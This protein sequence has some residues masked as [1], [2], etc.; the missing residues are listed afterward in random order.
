MVAVT[1]DSPRERL[2]AQVIQLKRSAPAA[3]PAESGTSLDLIDL[4]FSDYA[5]DSR[6]IPGWW[7][8]P[9]LIPS[10]AAICYLISLIF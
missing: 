10:L 3:A 5:R 8:M 2:T 9:L 6:F 1:N 7:I 4:E